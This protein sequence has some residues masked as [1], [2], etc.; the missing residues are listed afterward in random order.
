MRLLKYTLAP[1]AREDTKR[2]NQKSFFVQGLATIHAPENTDTAERAADTGEPQPTGIF[3]TPAPH[4]EP[5]AAA[6][7]KLQELRE[8]REKIRASIEQTRKS[9]AERRDNKE[10]TGPVLTNEERTAFDKMK[11]EYL[12]VNE[13]IK[14]EEGA[15]DVE[16]FLT[17]TAESE[18]RTRRGPGGSIDPTSDDRVPGGA[19]SYGDMLGGDRDTIREHARNEQRRSLAMQAWALSAI[20]P[21]A[22]TS[23][24]RQAVADTGIQFGGEIR[25]MGLGTEGHR[26]LRQRLAG[27][28]KERRIE[29]AS[30]LLPRLVHEQRA[31]SAV[32]GTT[33]QANLAPEIA[34]RA[35]ELAIVTVGGLVGVADTMVTPDGNK[36]SWPMAD[37]TSNEGVQI[38]EVTAQSLD[39]LA[40]STGIFSVASYE[41]WSNFIRLGN[42]T[43]RD[44]PTAFV[45]AVSTMIGERLARAINRKAT[46]GNGTGTLRGIEL[47]AVEGFAMPDAVTFALAGLFNLK[48]SVDVA[49][50]G[51]GTWM[52]ND[53]ILVELMLLSD[54]EDRPFLVEPNDG[55][56]TRL[57]NRPV[58]INNHMAPHGTDEPNRPR[59]IFG[60]LSKYKLR[61]VGDVR[62][63]VYRE[64]FAEFDQTAYDG[65]RGADGGVLNAGGNPI[66][67]MLK[68]AA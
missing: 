17:E 39:G 3:Y 61:L 6:V 16:K 26:E 9:V 57:L 11:A 54:A 25:I 31:V 12:G 46:I 4:T 33:A 40:P 36:M 32:A 48:H 56:L 64:R 27:C 34:A 55:S 29:I 14:A 2:K 44:S 49:Y 7:P 22:I 21:Q 58:E 52:M 38:D 60:D 63:M 8:K 68:P 65:K 18:Q 15:E 23:E 30:Q 66:K 19:G 5:K 1:I 42:V 35:M 37:D 28:G 13:Q 59:V 10:H 20:S 50:R 62:T 45:A 24:Q 51:V 41:F 43:L 53:E 67:S 47:G